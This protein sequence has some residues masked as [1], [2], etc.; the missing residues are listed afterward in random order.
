MGPPG[1]GRNS[2]SN[3][4][5]RHFNVVYVEPYAD[6][7]LKYIFSTVMEWLFISKP[8]P[9]FPEPI[10]AMKEGVV[11]NTITIYK[12]VMSKFRPTPAKSHYTFNLRDVSKIFQGI[13][14]SSG[15]AI[16]KEDDMVKLWA[17]EC[18]RVF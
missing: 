14:K 11:S 18:C 13:A 7:S 10:K 12:D 2:I 8:T 1:E 6:E 16:M 9:P 3:R 4:Y 5:V 15:K 17:H